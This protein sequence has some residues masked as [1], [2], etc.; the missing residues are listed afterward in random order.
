MLFRSGGF[1]GRVLTV[2]GEPVVRANVTLIDRHGRQAG[3]TIAGD[4]GRYALLPPSGGE[5]VLAGSA[6]GHAPHAH[7]ASYAGDGVA[8]EVD[9]ILPQ[10]AGE[11]S[12]AVTS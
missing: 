11:R 12:G 8:V 6:T 2:D 3:L 10:A 1:R 7:P 5:Y 4:D 9:L